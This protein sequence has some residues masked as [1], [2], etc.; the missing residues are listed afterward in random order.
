MAEQPLTTPAGTR[1][2]SASTADEHVRRTARIAGLRDFETPTLE[3]IERRRYELLGLTFALILAL[4]VAL[5]AATSYL[6]IPNFLSGLGRTGIAIR[7]LVVLLLVSFGGYV[8]E[9]ERHLG[10]LSRV[11]VNERVLSAAL[12][13]RLKE[14]SSLSEAGKA[15]V[16]MLELEDVLNVI[17]DGAS[18]LL[19]AD[20]GSVQLLEG[21]ELVVAAAAGHAQR[22]I[23]SRRSV[24]EGLAGYVART[25]EPLLIEGRPDMTDYGAVAHDREKHIESAISVPLEATDDLLGILNLN[26]T[27]GDR[28][29]NEYDLRA[30][31]LFGEHAAMAIRHARALRRE[32]EL[33]GQIAELDRLR[34]ELVGSMTH[35]LKTPL[36]T[37][38]GSAKLLQR[39]VNDLDEAKRGEVVDAIVRQSDR[40]LSLIERLLDAARS[41]TRASLNPVRIDIVP[42]IDRV[43]AAYG[44]AH[45]RDVTV[46]KETEPLFAYADP[47]AVEQVLANLL[48][49]A[50]KHA[51][52]ATAV[53]VRARREAGGAE[54]VVADNG[55][56]IPADIR[57]SLFE[58]Y[59]QGESHGR[60]VGLG[61]FI[62]SSLVTG[63]GGRVSV[64]SEPG[65]GTLFRVW[66]PGEGTEAG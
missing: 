63:M 14:I 16:S 51:P 47:D 7:A 5:A 44:H 48:E 1:L 21:D 59:T 6:D 52:E 40:L 4:V 32:R 17:L 10:R 61:L 29:Y 60:G 64:E 45:G 50:M 35:D 12:T 13:N 42:V 9:K 31:R 18:D 57:T 28:R 46:E 34:A 65:S 55:P 20:E 54:V 15:V 26:V 25:R 24:M 19:E 66:L 41:Q 8:W 33:R 11:L 58:A 39:R 49:N 3:Q 53:G 30:L 56:G 27:S 22:Y 43:C 62:V 36:T 2:T 37:I 23:G 38:L